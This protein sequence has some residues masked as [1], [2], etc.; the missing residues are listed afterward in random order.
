[1]HLTPEI[2]TLRLSIPSTTF[3]YLSLGAVITITI[4]QEGSRGNM[5][6]HGII[7]VPAAYRHGP[8]GLGGVREVGHGFTEEEGRDIGEAPCD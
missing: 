5:V 7:A 2:L 1:M 3:Q 8:Q 6:T 4:P